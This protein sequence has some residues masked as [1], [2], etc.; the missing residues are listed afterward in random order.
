MLSTALVGGNKLNNI[1]YAAMWKGL[2]N[3]DF[4][5]KYFKK[6]AIYPIKQTHIII[7][8]ITIFSTVLIFLFLESTVFV[9]L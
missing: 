3:Q 9:Q 4:E 2:N 1:P 7:F 5:K 8:S 6:S